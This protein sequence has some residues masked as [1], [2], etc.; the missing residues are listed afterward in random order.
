[1]NLR[2]IKGKYFRDDNKTV[3]NKNLKKQTYANRAQETKY[4]DVWTESDEF[5]TNQRLVEQA[6][7][8]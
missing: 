1:M 3:N 7:W 6:I 4:I 5:H 8:F 2:D